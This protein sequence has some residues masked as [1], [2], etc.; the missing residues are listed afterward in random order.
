[1]TIYISYVLYN[2]TKLHNEL[3]H[4]YSINDLCNASNILMTISWQVEM[5]NI[6]IWRVLLQHYCENQKK[7]S[8]TYIYNMYDRIDTIW[9]TN[10][11]IIFTSTIKQRHVLYSRSCNQPIQSK[12][13][14]WY[15]CKCMTCTKCNLT[16]KWNLLFM[17][18]ALNYINITLKV[19]MAL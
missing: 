19:K 5:A 15:T 8:Y 7:Y 17:P 18:I 14:I 10:N 12:P 16:P 9:Y 6:M 2:A 4:P 3:I 1:M 11:E 13:L